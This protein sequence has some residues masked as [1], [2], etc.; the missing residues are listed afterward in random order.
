M[1]VFMRGSWRTRG[2]Q[3]LKRLKLLNRSNTVLIGRLVSTLYSKL[4]LEGRNRAI[5]TNNAATIT[6]E[7]RNSITR[8]IRWLSGNGPRPEGSP[9]RRNGRG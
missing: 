5:T 6:R 4:R 3:S 7:M 8:V 1:L 9:E 2:F